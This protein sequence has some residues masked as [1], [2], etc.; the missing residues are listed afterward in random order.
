[1]TLYSQKIRIAIL[2]FAFCMAFGAARA[3]EISATSHVTAATIFPDRALVTREA[4]MHVPAG[5]HTLVINEVPAGFDESSLRVQGKADT[6][7]KIGSVEVKSVFLTEAADAAQRD[8]Q[9]QIEAKQD[10]KLLLE[11]QIVALDERKAFIEKIT[12][13]GAE[14]TSDAGT[15]KL[16]FAPDKWTQAWDL[17]QNGMAGTMKELV[18]QQIAERKLD[19]EIF[20]LSQEL[21]QI[22]SS[23]SKERR[24]VHVQIVVEH[25]TDLRLLLMYQTT[26]ASWEPVYD[27]RLDTS[28]GSLTLEQYGQAT[29]QTGEDWSDIELTFSTARPAQGSEMPQLGQWVVQ[30][31]SEARV[32]AAPMMH[33]A[34]G[35]VA[36]PYFLEQT[37]KA[38]KEREDTALKM[39]GSA[40]PEPI[41]QS[42]LEAHATVLAATPQTTE[43]TAEF[44]VPGKAD[45]KST[46]D[47]TK[48]YIGAVH[49][50]ASLNAQVT[51]RMAAQAYLFA[52]AVNKES[53]PLIPGTV[54]KYRD[55]AFIGNAALDLLRPNETANLSFGVDDRIKVTYRRTHD[56][57]NNPTLILVG[58]KDVQRSYETKIE[59]LHKDALDVTVFEQYPISGDAD[60]KSELLEDV[61]T[62]GFG[63]DP[64][65]RQGVIAWG[66]NLKPQEEKI[67]TLGF[68]VKYP[69]DR[70]LIGM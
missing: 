61:T 28:N 45:L 49:M 18:N 3:D 46:S 20:K 6:D 43:F 55:G 52:K 15:A 4:K 33:E 11:A 30:L 60:V 29:Q 44:K 13:A 69:K 53:Y 10:E 59:N 24:D 38:Q 36:S 67:F 51:P 34:P 42:K 27:A 19:K 8:R 62:P 66:A 14:K 58:D 47:P 35:G 56:E 22:R 1:M 65:N 17:I 31:L 64:E 48:L 5:A 9:A 32:A 37:R 7:I 50:T 70:Q 68:R 39:G 63:K 12:G 25:D 57:Q 40:L 41:E 26:G 54:A 23:L 2:S 16:D 21:A